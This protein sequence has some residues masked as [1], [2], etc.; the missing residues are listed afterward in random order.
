MLQ[1]AHYILTTDHFC[2]QINWIVDA[3]NKKKVKKV[4]LCA[5]SSVA[6]HA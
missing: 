6:R 1:P 3:I 2:K 4:R 5:K